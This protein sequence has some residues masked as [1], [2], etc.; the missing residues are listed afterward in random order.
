M[1]L[2]SILNNIILL[3]GDTPPASALPFVGAAAV[4][5]ASV[6]GG[7]GAGASVFG[8]HGAAAVDLLGG[9]GF[10]EG[11][12][13]AGDFALAVFDQEL[14]GGAFGGGGHGGGGHGGGGH[15]GGGH[16]G[17]GH[18]GDAGFDS[19]FE[20]GVGRGG[21]VVFQQVAQPQYF[22]APAPQRVVRFTRNLWK[23][24]I[25]ALYRRQVSGNLVDWYHTLPEENKLWVN[26]KI[27]E[28]STGACSRHFSV[29]EIERVVPPRGGAS[30]F[31]GGGCHGGGGHG[32]AG[33]GGGGHGGGGHG[34]AGHGGGGSAV[35][36][37]FGG[38]A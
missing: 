10:F 22:Q 28:W 3:G 17:G 33:H 25:T 19:V 36:S 8:G 24:G 21:E 4:G 9:G 7:H 15:G 38:L 5:S 35:E 31:G 27:S 30:V 13:G 20:L 14:L 37:I 23:R 32:G 2:D 6:F 12:P 29:D 18:G 34:G 1:S 16:G 26:Q 11:G